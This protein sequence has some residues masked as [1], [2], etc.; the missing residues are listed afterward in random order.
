MTPLEE[1]WTYIS[2]HLHI[3]LWTEEY[4]CDLFEATWSLCQQSFS[5]L[6]FL[7]DVIL[8]PPTKMDISLQPKSKS[9]KER[10]Q[11]ETNTD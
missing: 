4:G 5:K 7:L 10:K 1:I 6:P 2:L 9:A 8:N 3:G 11:A